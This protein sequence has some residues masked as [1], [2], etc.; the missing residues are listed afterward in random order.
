[1]SSSKQVWIR[2]IWVLR[3]GGYIQGQWE[4][5]VTKVPEKSGVQGMGRFQG[6]VS[7][8]AKSLGKIDHYQKL[9]SLVPLTPVMGSHSTD[10]E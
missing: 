6:Q 4:S 1:M 2:A 8:E 10:L 9:M 5:L 7:N 3:Q